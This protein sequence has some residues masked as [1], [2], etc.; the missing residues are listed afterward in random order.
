MNHF[1]Y[2]IY[3]GYGHYIYFDIFR[4]VDDPTTTESFVNPASDL[5]LGGPH[6]QVAVRTFGGGGVDADGSARRIRGPSS[7]WYAKLS[8]GFKL[9]EACTS[10]SD[11][12][13]SAT[14]MRKRRVKE[15]MR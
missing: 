7:V 5:P 4:Y 11:A 12:H 8:C 9:N 14:R 13:A 1:Y 2:S 6:L 10:L 3:D 15:G